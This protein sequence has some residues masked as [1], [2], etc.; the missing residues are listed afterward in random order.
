MQW[1]TYFSSF[2]WDEGSINPTDEIMTGWKFEA[3]RRFLIWLDKSIST[4]VALSSPI[5]GAANPLRAV[6]SGESMGLPIGDR[7]SRDMEI[8]FGR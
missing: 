7:E 8:T 3:H 6:M 4:Y 1:S 2:I 5:I